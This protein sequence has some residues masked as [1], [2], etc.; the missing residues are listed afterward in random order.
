[1]LAPIWQG[2]H[3]AP[4]GKLCSKIRRIY[5]D[6]SQTLTEGKGLMAGPA[7]AGKGPNRPSN[8]PRNESISQ[9]GGRTGGPSFET[10]TM[11]QD[12]FVGAGQRSGS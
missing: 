7:N 2:G 9:T 4:P 11:D 8:C 3:G 6:S 10:P 12:Q 5:Y 1:M